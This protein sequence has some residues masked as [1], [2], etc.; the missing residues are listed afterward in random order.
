MCRRRMVE[1]DSHGVLP[2]TQLMRWLSPDNL[3]LT[4]ADRFLL[5][6]HQGTIMSVGDR[7][8]APLDLQ[9]T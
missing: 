6:A 5:A 9:V 7:N 4:V 2:V 8:L 1:G 3:V